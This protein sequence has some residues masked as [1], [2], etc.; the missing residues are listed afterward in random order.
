MT[1]N[2]IN[3]D[4]YTELSLYTVNTS[5]IYHSCIIPVCKH[6]AR[7]QIK[8]IYNKDKALKA[9]Y[10]VVIQ[11]LKAFYKEFS[12]YEICANASK[13]YELANV[14]TRKEIASYL[15]DY[16]QETIEELAD[17]LSSK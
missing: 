17:E 11:A 8:G 14:A 7:K 10:N 13:W 5:K 6:L 3:Q 2:T 15:L 12:T 1:N 9:F 16:Y 4:M